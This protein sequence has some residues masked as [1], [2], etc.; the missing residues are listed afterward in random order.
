MDRDFDT[1]RTSM[2]F[3]PEGTTGDGT[4]TRQV[5]KLP[6]IL[7]IDLFP[8][9]LKRSPSSY[10]RSVFPS[11]EKFR[12]SKKLT[13]ISPVPKSFKRVRSPSS[14]LRQYVVRAAVAIGGFGI[15]LTSHPPPYPQRRD[16]RN[17]NF[18]GTALTSLKLR[19]RQ[20]S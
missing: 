1:S 11:G 3:A 2:T 7:H 19:P 20:T 4:A 10:E 12:C 9:W 16:R 6:F 13:A 15:Q 5:C 18:E 8:Q 17:Q 14:C